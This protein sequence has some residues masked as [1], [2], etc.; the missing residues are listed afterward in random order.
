MNDAAVDMIQKKGVKNVVQMRVQMQCDLWRSGQHP[1]HCG[2]KQ[3]AMQTLIPGYAASRL[4]KV[5]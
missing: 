2:Q 4:S 3:C 1:V 5:N